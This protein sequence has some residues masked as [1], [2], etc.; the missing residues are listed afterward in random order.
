VGELIQNVFTEQHLYEHE[1]RTTFIRRYRHVAFIKRDQIEI[2]GIGRGI[3][4]GDPTTLC[5][6]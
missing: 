4:R 6:P 5:F 3:C 1:Q 2:V